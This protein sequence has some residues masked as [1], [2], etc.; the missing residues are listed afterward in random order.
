[1]EPGFDEGRK[2][3]HLGMTELMI[4]VGRFV[5]D[6]YREIGHDGCRHIGE[7]MASLGEDRQGARTEACDEF[8]H[9]H[10]RA[11]RNGG[12]RRPFLALVGLVYRH[13][14]Y[15]RPWRPRV[16]PNRSGQASIRPLRG[17][18]SALFRAILSE[19]DMFG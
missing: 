2:G 15:R 11:H 10:Q 16:R 19:E 3:F 6:P 14:W 7:I 1:E 18:A 4:F 5:R 13:F 12:K 17:A 9:R 8:R